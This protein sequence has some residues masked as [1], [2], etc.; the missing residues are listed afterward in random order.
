MKRSWL[1][2]TVVACLL[3]AGACE[4]AAPSSSPVS[5]AGTHWQVISIAGRAPL[6]RNAPTL[7]FEA[8]RVSGTAGCNGYGS[9]AVSVAGNTISLKDLAM[10][11]MGCVDQAVMEQET[12]YFQTL[13][14]ASRIAVADGRLSLSGPRGELVFAR[15]TP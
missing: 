11:A 12:S 5:L 4:A 3:A 1:L 7:A 2:L 10:T 9:T 15:V 6:P 13:A 14:A 8:G